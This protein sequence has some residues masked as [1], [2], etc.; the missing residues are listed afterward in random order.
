MHE[1]PLACTMMNEFANIQIGINPLAI[2]GIKGIYHRVLRSI[3]QYNIN[4]SHTEDRASG[5]GLLISHQDLYNDIEPGSH[6]LC[7]ITNV[8]QWIRNQQVSL[9]SLGERAIDIT[10]RFVQWY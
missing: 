10:S 5:T 8:D 6:S 4:N 1:C 2:H 9:Y 7:I 3:N